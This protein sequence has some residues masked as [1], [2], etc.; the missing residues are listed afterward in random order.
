M[1]SAS[2]NKTFPSFLL[3]CVYKIVSRFIAN[4]IKKVLDKIIAKDQTGFIIKG[5]YIG[6]N[7][8]LIYDIMHYTQKLNIPGM[9]LLSDFEKA[10]DFLVVSGVVKSIYK[11]KNTQK[12][13][14]QTKQQQHHEQLAKKA[15]LP[16]LDFYCLC[17]IPHHKN[18]V[19]CMDVQTS[20]TCSDQC[21]LLCIHTGYV[22]CR[23]LR[24]PVVLSK[25]V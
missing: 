12:N 6:E 13:N 25:S 2:L 18:K 21:I 3:N 19:T 1:L 17:C 9:L 4:R 24:L 11:K 20:Y 23:S 8:R 22:H 16:S 7:I 10:F 14:K 15:Q 5:R